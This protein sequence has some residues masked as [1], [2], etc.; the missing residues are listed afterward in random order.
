ML[1]YYVYMCMYTRPVFV[2][3]LL[4]NCIVISYCSDMIRPQLSAIL[5]ELAVLT[6]VCSLCGRDCTR[7]CP[8]IIKYIELY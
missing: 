1:P 7:E 3:N 2:S 8:D 5:R 4:E 6:D